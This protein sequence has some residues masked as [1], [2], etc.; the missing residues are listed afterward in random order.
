MSG[1]Q[2]TKSTNKDKLKPVNT[3]QTSGGQGKRQR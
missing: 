2:S 3:V 1:G